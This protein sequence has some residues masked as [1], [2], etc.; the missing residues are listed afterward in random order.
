M[1]AGR[2]SFEKKSFEP[3]S[4]DPSSH[5]KGPFNE[6]D[7]RHLKQLLDAVYDAP[8]LRAEFVYRLSRELDE[9]FASLY[10]DA[11]GATGDVIPL[12]EQRLTSEGMSRRS[13]LRIFGSAAAAAVLLIAVAF[14]GN[15]PAYGWAAMLEALESCDWVQAITRTTTASGEQAAIGWFSKSARIA[16]REEGEARVYLNFNANTAESFDPTEQ[17]VRQQPLQNA[18]RLGSEFLKLLLSS[19]DNQSTAGTIEVIDE[20]VREV[21]VE[22]GKQLQLQVSLRCKDSHEISHLEF[23]VNPETKLPVSGKVL[24]EGAKD[25]A[26]SIEFAYPRQGPESIYALGVPQAVKVVVVKSVSGD[27]VR[28]KPIEVSGQP[29]KVNSKPTGVALAGVEQPTTAVVV[30]ELVVAGGPNEPT[31]QPTAEIEAEPAANEAAAVGARPALEM[32]RAEAKVKAPAPL[33]KPLAPAELVEQLNTLLADFWK[34]QGIAPAEPAA[35]T[36]FL[37]RV[38]LDLTGRIPMVSEV[39]AFLDDP[40]PNRSE[41]LVDDLLSR[42]DH[43]THLAAV[44]RSVLLPEGVDLNTYGGTNKFDRWLADRFSQNLSYDEIVRQLLLAEGRVSESG[45]ILFYASLKLN[46]EE[47][48]AK[49]SRV[50]LGTRME[51][52]QCHDHPFDDRIAQTDFWG[53]AA[54]FAQISRPQGK[55]EMT[56]PVLRVHD[57]DFGEVMLPD[58]ETIVPPRLPDGSG[59][60]ATDPTGMALSRR[61]QLVDWL[62]NHNNDQFSRAAVNRVWQQLFGRGL[63]EPVDDIRPANKPI[64]PEVLDL[65]TRD[66]AA[67]EFDLRRLLRALVLTDAYQLS[68]GTPQDDPAQA[69]CFARMNMKY[70]TADQL[71][72][73]IA[74]AT[75][76]E[77]MA[78][79]APDGA[80][81]RTENMSR[82]Q[83]IEQFRVAAGDRTD[84]QAGVPQAL[85][86][87]HGSVVNGAT[88]LTSS[89]LLKSLSAPFF[90][91]EQRLETLFL[92]TLSREPRDTEREKLLTYLKDAKD[93]DEKLG[94]LGDVLW[95]LLNS[96][97][98]TFI[99]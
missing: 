77:A 60:V 73:C 8:P 12:A 34:A 72:D 79:S 58:T 1:Q 30:E 98:F 32:A 50:F 87:M 11:N 35:D 71:F 17:V 59:E 33:P 83:F 28:G 86:L 22:N 31:A 54:H 85:T 74:V 63:I 43:A 64:S 57:N 89:G 75:R 94:I 5:E 7:E 6:A 53:F 90:T 13:G 2:D 82:Q 21:A 97:E 76:N 15:R 96:A 26:Q 38:Y 4:F 55:M 69:L 39:Y 92:A 78:G 42:R 37:R 52:A 14:W 61:Q 45:P 29:I 47:I 10:L 16:A 9:Q 27:L 80:I 88:D 3:D 40:D 19:S 41:K 48:A 93:T 67:S 23:K 65:L 36:E 62:T 91:D 18:E 44:W 56:S 68:S 99:H 70:F 84:Y 81:A 46:P 25:V 66:F 20:S 24:R 49:A 95:A 51:C